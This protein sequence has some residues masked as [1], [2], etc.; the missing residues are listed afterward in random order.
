MV[1][2][3]KKFRLESKVNELDNCSGNLDQPNCGIENGKKSTKK[4]KVQML[5]EGMYSLE[6]EGH[7]SGCSVN[8]STGNQYK[9]HVCERRF[10]T[11]QV[12]FHA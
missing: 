5:V 10:P 7:I 6:T 3:L 12:Y 1:E 9:C 2:I 8:N 4:R 11:E